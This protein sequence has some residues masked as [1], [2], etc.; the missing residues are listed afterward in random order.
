MYEEPLADINSPVR[1]WNMVHAGLPFFQTVLLNN[2]GCAMSKVIFVVFGEDFF[3]GGEP[4]Q[5]KLWEIRNNQYIDIRIV[6]TM[7]PDQQS[8]R[9]IICCLDIYPC[10]LPTYQIS[11][12][13]RGK[14]VRSG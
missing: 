7:R 2:K 11:T 12:P 4:G 1:I 9:R 6:N 5:I 8:P 13:T 14:I 10:S 3:L